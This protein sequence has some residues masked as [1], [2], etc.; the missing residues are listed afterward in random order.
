[1]NHFF[2]AFLLLALSAVFSFAG[3]S[4]GGIGISILATGE[5]VR[6]VEVIPG[7]PAAEAGIETGD[8]ITAV[9]GV[10]LAGNDIEASKDA[11]R[12]TVGKFGP[13]YYPKRN[14]FP[15]PFS[16]SDYHS[17]LDLFCNYGMVRKISE[18]TMG[19]KLVCCAEQSAGQNMRAFGDAEWTC[20]E[21]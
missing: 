3:E 13:C 7:S 9:D 10:A 16:H 8:R 18:I 21:S 5:G 1:M 17:D 14:H 11:L 12:G 15:S 4:F 20:I 19:Q 6:V 2:T